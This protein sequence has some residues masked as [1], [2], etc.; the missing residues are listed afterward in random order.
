MLQANGMT[1]RKRVWIVTITAGAL[2]LAA[3]SVLATRIPLT[4][5]IARSRVTAGLAERL[6]S[7]VR[8]GEIS[9]R[10]LPTLLIEGTDLV[11]HHRGRSD[12]PPLISVSKFT[13]S[14]SLRQMWNKD[15]DHVKL[16]GLTIQIP[17]GED[18]DD[19]KAGSQED[20][21]PATESQHYAEGKQVV[22]RTLEASDARVVILRRDPGKT[23]RTWT[24]HTLRAQNLSTN[25]PMSFEATLTNAVPPGQ[26][27]TDGS[28]GPWH[29][30]E[31]GH[32]PIFGRFVFNDADLS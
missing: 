8:L 10:L 30:D 32:T 17:P 23:P 27:E 4:S 19:E 2:L 21:P 26:I 16:D 20:T 14:T 1:V 28:F 3:L 7:D 18:K 6:G 29:K 9:L 31:P 11:I 15:V 22:V 12:V 24:L 13:I 5:T 25:T